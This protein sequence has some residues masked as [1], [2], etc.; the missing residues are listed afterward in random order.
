MRG[1]SIGLRASD[2]VKVCVFIIVA[3]YDQVSRSYVH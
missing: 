1:C 3:S 2:G